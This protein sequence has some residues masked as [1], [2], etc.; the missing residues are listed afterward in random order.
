MGIYEI[1]RTRDKRREVCREMGDIQIY[2]NIKDTVSE[3]L[4]IDDQTIETWGEMGVF[5]EGNATKK[6]RRHGAAVDRSAVLT[7]KH[8][9]SAPGE[10]DA[11]EVHGSSFRVVQE[12]EKAGKEEGDRV[13]LRF[14]IC[15]STSERV[16]EKSQERRYCQHCQ[17]FQQP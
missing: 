12:F 13:D 17:I 16:G 10:Q 2:I 15:C 3:M 7:L 14:L 6:T 5:I 9:I 8:E 4:E 11:N 1:L